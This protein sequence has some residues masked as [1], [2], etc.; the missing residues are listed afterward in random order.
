MTGSIRIIFGLKDF[1]RPKKMGYFYYR[2]P[3]K[4]SQLSGKTLA[5]LD[6]Y[7]VDE[8][9]L[10]EIFYEGIAKLLK[11]KR[12]SEKIPFLE[13]YETENMKESTKTIFKKVVQEFIFESSD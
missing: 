9:Y 2:L 4:F 5:V 1:P 13:N 6:L 7:N 12:F 8:Q 3:C 10:T 11:Q